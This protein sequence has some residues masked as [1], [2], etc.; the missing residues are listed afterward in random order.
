MCDSMDGR[1]L[2]PTSPV[3][4]YVATPN[5]DAMAADGVNFVRTYAAS[6]QCVP[7]RTSM[8]AGR[9]L[10]QTRTFSNG[11]GFA[12]DPTGALDNDCVSSYDEATCAAFGAEQG[13]PR[14]FFD[15]LAPAVD[16]ALFGKVDVGAN[17]LSRFGPSPTV[18]GF[19]GGLSLPILTRSADIRKPTK[20]TPSAITNDRDNHVHPEDWKMHDQCLDWLRTHPASQTAAADG[21]GTRPSDDGAHGGSAARS[22]MMYCSLN[23]PH[24]PFDTN[25][26]WLKAVDEALVRS[27][28]PNWPSLE[29]LHPHDQVSPRP[30]PRPHPHPALAQGALALTL[31][32]RA[33]MAHTSTASRSVLPP[34]ARP[35][36]DHLEGGGRRVHDLR[37]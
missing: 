2:D 6:P 30:R 34:P 29:S 26:T 24:P 4:K 15:A 1:V 10:D 19:H 8:L 23:I 13:P 33:R 9:R 32:Q 3:S 31:T 27:T 7:S 28:P 16:V 21:H 36:H 12:R 25:Q 35:V 11:R 20:P 18:P 17:V 37:L 14:T 22:W 5:L